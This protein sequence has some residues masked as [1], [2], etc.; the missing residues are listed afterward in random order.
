MGMGVGIAFQ[1]KFSG[2]WELSRFIRPITHVWI[3]KIKSYPNI[4]IYI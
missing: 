2:E 1:L 3:K 4:Y